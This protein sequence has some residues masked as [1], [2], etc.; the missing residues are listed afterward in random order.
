MAIR[1]VSSP[2]LACS[3]SPTQIPIRLDVRQ[4]LESN[5]T[6]E[7]V[8]FVYTLDEAHDVWFETASG[9]SK[10]SV[11]DGKVGRTEQSIHH[12]VKLRQGPGSGPMDSV[13]IT[14]TIIGAAGRETHNA[15]SVIISSYQ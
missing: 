4:T 3:P 8:T 11:R 14:Q 2:R 9:L 13:Q 1:V 7:S 15:C 5:R 12:R 10:K 6:S